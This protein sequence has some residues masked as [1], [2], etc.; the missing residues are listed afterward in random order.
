MWSG[1]QGQARRRA[2]WFVLALAF[3]LLVIVCRLVQL[4][5]LQ[6]GYYRAESDKRTTRVVEL[7]ARR[8]NILDRAGRP[9]ALSL[10]AESIVVNPMRAPQPDVAAAYLAP[11]LGLDQRDL[12]QRLITAARQRRGFLWIKRRVSF[13]ES[14]QLRRLGFGWVE[15]RRESLRAYPKGILA[16]HV[17]GGVD[18]EERGNGGVEQSFE[19]DLRGKAGAAH[20][21][22]DVVRRGVDSRTERPAEPGANITLTIDERIQHVAER[23]LA[24]A[25]QESRSQTGSVVV[26]D[27][28]TGDILALASYPAYDPNLPFKTRQDAE[29]RANHA[30]S[31]PFEPGSVF[32]VITV[33]AA[34][35]TTRLTPETIIACG[36]GRLNLFG[37]V[38]RDHHPYDMLPVA[39]VLAKSSNIGAIQIGLAVGERNLLNYVRRFGFGRPTGVPLPGE[40]AGK[41]RELENWGRSSI[42]SVAMG[43]EISATTM[44]L[45]QA[46]AA[47]ANGGLLIPPRL[48]LSKQRQGQK[49]ELTPVGSPRSILR[50]ETAITMRRMMEGV[51]LN[52]TGTLARLDGYT[53]GG[54][55]GSAQIF[56][57]ACRCYL[58][59][60]NSSFAGFAP[61]ANPAAV[62]VVTINGA[63][64]FGGAVAAPVFREVASA[65]LRLRNVPRDLPDNPPPRESA[66][67]ELADL[68]IPALESLEELLP[69]P[70]T[71]ERDGPRSVWGPRVPDFYG[72]TMRAVLEE[73]ARLGFPVEVSGSGVVRAQAPTPGSILPH[74]GRIRIVFAR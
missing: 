20:V 66:P 1:G 68:A 15:F 53:A 22:R 46:T 60:Y 8:G 13:A 14:Q 9:L 17:L 70:A 49:A 47:I 34:M 57:P 3:W 43:H 54:K 41:V 39:G 5:V 55:T 30:V 33:A 32:K 73:T 59:V 38:I 62:V 51:V 25:V 12:E 40:S 58:H 21:I 52:G 72:K 69:E 64:V 4:Q 23:E 26:L 48:V 7:P 42:G 2:T 24:K 27:P 65:A 50:P 28:K 44:Q 19:E 56:D 16:A 74:N 63:S 11:V 67:V 18:F 45:A 36:R 61:V 6:H 37:R 31:V 35:E 71:P 29:K 10:P